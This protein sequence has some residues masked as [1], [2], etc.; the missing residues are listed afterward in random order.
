MKKIKIN[1][2]TNIWHNIK[3]KYKLNFQR[4]I[5]LG[6]PLIITSQVI[7]QIDA[8]FYSKAFQSR[9]N[10]RIYLPAN[11]NTDIKKKY[12][13]IYY[14][15]GWSGRYKWD[16]MSP[17][18]DPLYSE[19]GRKEPP[20]IMEWKEYTKNNNVIIVTWDGYEPNLH[21]GTDIRDGIRFNNCLPYD[22]MRAHDKI[23]HYWGWD[24]RI[25]FRELIKNV[26]CNFRTI[27]DRDHRAITGLSMG[28]LEALYIAGQNKDYISSVSAFCPADNIPLYGPKKNQVAF[29]I[30]EMYRS[31]KGLAV[32][33]SANDGDWL[34]YNDLEIKRLYSAADLTHFE[35]HYAHFP[36]HWAA[37]YK[38]QLDFHLSQF[39]KEHPIPNN[40]G[41]ACPSY[42]SFS[43]W[44]YSFNVKRKEPALT[45]LEDVSKNH[46]KILSRSFIPDG[47][48]IKNEEIEIITSGIYNRN[49]DYSLIFYNLSNALFSYLPV[50]SLPDG[51]LKFMLDGGGYIV[52]INNKKDK[53]PI[54][55]IVNK[56]NVN[57]KYFEV[58]K[59]YGLDFDVINIGNKEAE[60]IEVTLFSNHP[61]IM[62]NENHINIPSIK[63][64]SS[65]SMTNQFSFIIPEYQEETS[66]GRLSFE[67]KADGIVVDT[68]KV[69]FFT[70]P[71]SQYADN[72]DIIILDGRTVPDVPIFIQG[73]DEVQKISISGGKG[74]GN[75]ICEKGEDVLVFIRISK[76]ISI[77]DTNSFH[78]TYLLNSHDDN[79]VSVNKL[80]YDEKISQAAATSVSS[81]ISIDNN[82]P[83]NHIINLWLRLESLYNDANDPDAGSRAIY[84]RKY[85]YRKV[86]IK[87]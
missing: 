5:L 60:N 69:I 58:K 76:G 53:K 40:W 47:P 63:S 39:K 64:A 52:G 12:P 32:R 79:F 86:Q 57:Y 38:Q 42:S 8:S 2:C 1:N 35:F 49:S 6:F 87:L 30:L 19:N 25:Y 80:R 77:N 37:D 54:I 83:Q 41:H 7:A 3:R 72:E 4:I 23:D 62:F 46:L 73:K 15:H 66:V 70:T 22:F 71:K 48:I 31:L 14:F 11:Y 75:G 74:N 67:I 26:D 85:D 10:Y 43:T 13:V 16:Y 29:P 28:G 24:F 61:F 65:V 44:G 34:K 81:I 68:Q 55:R 59:T 21:P 17:K 20:Y 56:Q 50:K 45:L 84:A 51:K 78:K 36:A 18:D 9:R 82:I 33:V 27:P